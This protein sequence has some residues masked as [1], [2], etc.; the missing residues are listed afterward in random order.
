MSGLQ[1]LA[2]FARIWLIYELDR[3][4]APK[5]KVIPYLDNQARGIFATRSPS[6]PNPLGLS[7]VRLMGVADNILSIQ[8]VDMLDG[9]PLLDIKPYVPKFDSF[10]DSLAGWFDHSINQVTNADNRFAC[11]TNEPAP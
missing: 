7:C 6:R 8:D 11:K 2:G 1:D 9:T 10:P 5:L 4:S 3:C